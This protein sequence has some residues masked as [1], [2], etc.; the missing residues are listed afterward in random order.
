MKKLSSIIFIVV[1]FMLSCSVQNKKTV[2]IEEISYK[3]TEHFKVRTSNA[4]YYLEKQSGGFSGILDMNGT[5]WIQFRKS[6]SASVPRSADSDFRG[7]PNLVHG[8]EQ[9]GVGHPG[10]DQCISKITNDSTISVTSKSGKYAFDWIFSPESAILIIQKADT[11]RNYWFL[12]EGPIAG[13]YNPAT[14]M[15]F[16]NEGYHSEKPDIIKGDYIHGLFKWIC[17]GDENYDQL[18][19]L[20]HEIPDTL[21]D[22]IMYMGNSG[23][24]D[25]SGDGMVV[26]GFG[27]NPDHTPLM[28]TI[29][30]TFSVRFIEKTGKTPG[31]IFSQIESEGEK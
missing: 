1:T 9:G 10:F 17:L 13:K 15:I 28:K 21:T 30:N 24:W 20:K 8:G 18:L 3:G 22:V 31:D 7:L 16:T 14:H 19:L 27:R 5:D 25:E 23:A 11:M 4:T 26:A 29:P 2:I 12:Y 6:D